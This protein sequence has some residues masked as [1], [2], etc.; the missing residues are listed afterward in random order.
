MLDPLPD[1]EDPDDPDD[2]ELPAGW[3]PEPLDTPLPPFG[4]SSDTIGFGAGPGG[5]VFGVSVA[6]GGLTPF[7]SC[8]STT[9]GYGSPWPV[10]GGS[11]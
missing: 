8:G 7:A 4:V 11:A 9:V 2:P 10:S 6:A 5:V 1:A 3:L